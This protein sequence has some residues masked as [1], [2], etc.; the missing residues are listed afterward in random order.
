MPMPLVTSQFSGNY[1]QPGNCELFRLLVRKSRARNIHNR[2]KSFPMGIL[3]RRKVRSRD[4]P[5]SAQSLRT[6]L[7]LV[8]GLER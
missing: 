1:R 4:C 2:Q 5:L 6:N 7:P 3:R 8:E